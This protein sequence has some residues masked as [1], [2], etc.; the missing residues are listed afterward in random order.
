MGSRQEMIP[1]ELFFGV[2]SPDQIAMLCSTSLTI[3][4]VKSAKKHTGRI[5]AP[6][7]KPSH[8]FQGLLQHQN[9][10]KGG[11]IWSTSVLV[12]KTDN[13][14]GHGPSRRDQSS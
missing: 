4:T 6:K 3:L 10:G 2:G 5:P 1:S 11:N 9:S 14:K 8:N 12:P 13:K 7:G